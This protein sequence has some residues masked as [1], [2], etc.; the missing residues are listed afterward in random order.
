[1]HTLSCFP[2]FGHPCLDVNDSLLIKQTSQSC[3]VCKY[4]M[5][6]LT[7]SI[8]C[9]CLFYFCLTINGYTLL[10]P[11]KFVDLVRLVSSLTLP[12]F[13]S[14]VAGTYTTP[15]LCAKK[16]KMFAHSHGPSL[17]SSA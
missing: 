11:S 3:S 9:I 17:K 12:V 8:Q 16:P 4:I 2:W 7:Q 5:L 13:F 14:S 15:V 1:M 10:S 6:C